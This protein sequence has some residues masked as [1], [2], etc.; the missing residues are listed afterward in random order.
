MSHDLTEASRTNM[1]FESTINILSTE[2]DG[3]YIVSDQCESFTFRSTA[4]RRE[5]ETE[6][7][8]GSRSGSVD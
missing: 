1:S 7:F 3:Y 4:K 5:N 6:V 8:K 2:G